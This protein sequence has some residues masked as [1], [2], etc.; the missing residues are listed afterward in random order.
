MSPYGVWV[1]T[2]QKGNNYVYF[3]VNVPLRG[4]GCDSKHQQ[5]RLLLRRHLLAIMLHRT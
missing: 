3:V 4:V 2:A 5:I 1:V